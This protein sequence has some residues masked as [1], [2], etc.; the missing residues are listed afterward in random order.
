VSGNP[1]LYASR[2]LEDLDELADILNWNMTCPP[3]EDHCDESLNPGL[4]VDSVTFQSPTGE[5]SYPSYIAVY[6]AQASQYTVA[7][8]SHACGGPT[9]SLLPDTG[10]DLCYDNTGVIECPAPGQPFYGQ[11][12][13]YVTNPMSYTVSQDGLTVTDNVT[14]LMWQRCSAGLSGTGCSTG[15]AATMTW[16]N[17][18]TYCDGL[19]FGGHADW[20]LPDEY[21]LQ[22]IIHYGRY[23]PAIDTTAFPGT[24]AGGYWSSST[25]AGYT[26]A[27]WNVHFSYG[28]VNTN[29]KRAIF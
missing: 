12:A 3:G 14:G 1:D 6:G 21:E 10:Q 22:G 8:T 2:Y 13:Q 20:R 17:A 25:Y 27:A 16:A 4:S 15:S 23:N 29:T 18:I 19:S 28:G 5:P 24:L 26:N 9:Q 7:V 11:D